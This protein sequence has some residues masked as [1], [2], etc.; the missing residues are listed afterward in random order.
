M[1]GDIYLKR[2][3]SV[4]YILVAFGAL[5]YLFSG[6]RFLYGDGR[7]VLI[8]GKQLWRISLGELSIADRLAMFGIVS[9]PDVVLLYSYWQLFKLAGNFRR[10]AVFHNNNASLL[11]RTGCGLITMGFLNALSFAIGR[12]YLYWRGISPWFGDSTITFGV[13]YN[14]VM[15][16]LFL[17]VLGQVMRRASELEENQRLIV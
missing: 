8:H 16:G 12:C 2:W 11:V 13:K 7:I 3:S 4:L 1:Y 17:F 9:P 6:A 5:Y 10:G 14:Y 15:V